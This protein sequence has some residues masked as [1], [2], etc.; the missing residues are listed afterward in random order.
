M[1]RTDFSGSDQ[2]QLRVNDN[3]ETGAG[4]AQETIT[5][6]EIS[7]FEN[8]SNP[9]NIVP[10]DQIVDEDVPLFFSSINN[11]AL[12]VSDPDDDS[13]DASLAVSLQVTS[14][15]LTLSTITGLAFTTGDKHVG[16]L[17]GF[18]R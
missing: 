4:D 3:G 11:N 16:F 17:D 14:G 18:Q 8:N 5:S 10:G 1:P 13:A 2:L 12:T 15:T 9:S 6:L 7:V